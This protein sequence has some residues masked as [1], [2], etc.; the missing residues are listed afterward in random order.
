LVIG[1]PAS[2][3]NAY[4]DYAAAVGAT[5]LYFVMLDDDDS[6]VVGFAVAVAI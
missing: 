6:V 5:D 4:Y 2:H 3:S 1:V